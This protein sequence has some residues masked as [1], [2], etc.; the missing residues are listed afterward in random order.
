MEDAKT[1][2][3]ILE[4]E[5][6]AEMNSDNEELLESIR[7]ACWV[8]DEEGN[9][10]LQIIKPVEIDLE[11]GHLVVEFGDLVPCMAQIIYD[12]DLVIPPEE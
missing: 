5:A 3:K 2:L 4:L 10:V 11:N 1:T 12:A 7:I 8:Y 6:L 9:L